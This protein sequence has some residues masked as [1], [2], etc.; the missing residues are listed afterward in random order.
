MADGSE[1]GP[2]EDVTTAVEG[3]WGKGERDGNR[4]EGGVRGEGGIIGM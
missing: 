2:V 1:C 3:R 4:K